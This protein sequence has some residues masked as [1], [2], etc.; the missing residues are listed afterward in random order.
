MCFPEGTSL[1]N[2]PD[3]VSKKS[4]TQSESIVQLNTVNQSHCCPS[5]SL[6]LNAFGLNSDI[7]GIS[8][9]TAC[10]QTSLLNE[11]E[12]V[13]MLTE[14]IHFVY[15]NFRSIPAD[16]ERSQNVLTRFYQRYE[17]MIVYLYRV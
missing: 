12:S 13:E 9:K 1:R 15:P 4:R 5:A 3:E 8:D 7:S 16:R 14:Q 10:F 6:L 17:C 2:T 11:T